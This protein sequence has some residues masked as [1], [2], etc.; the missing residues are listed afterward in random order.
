[1]TR[2]YEVRL[3]KVEGVCGPR[4][5]LGECPL[6]KD[7]LP[8]LPAAS[9]PLAMLL[10]HFHTYIYD[11]LPRANCMHDAQPVVTIANGSFVDAGAENLS[12]EAGP[13]L[14]HLSVVRVIN[15]SL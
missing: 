7:E 10:S 12:R 5:D 4:A 6:L 11:R 8:F 15:V 2:P 13:A 1:M 14:F 9:P 3:A